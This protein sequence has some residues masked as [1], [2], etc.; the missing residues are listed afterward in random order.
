[1]SWRKKIG[2]EGSSTVYLMNDQKKESGVR[3]A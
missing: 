1:V 3:A 2:D